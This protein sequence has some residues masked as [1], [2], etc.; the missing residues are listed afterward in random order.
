MARVNQPPRPIRVLSVDDNAPLRASRRTLFAQE[1]GIEL[2]A[3]AGDG[4]AGVELAATLRPDVVLLDIEMPVMNGIEAGEQIKRRLPDTRII[5][6]VAETT[7]RSQALALGADAFL[8]KDTPIDTLI[9]TNTRRRGGR[10]GG[11]AAV[12]D[13]RA[14]RRTGRAH[15][16]AAA[17]D[18]ARR[19]PACGGRG[20]LSIGRRAATVADNAA[21]ENPVADTGAAEGG[22]KPHAAAADSQRRRRPRPGRRT[23]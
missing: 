16:P 19:D 7:W 12:P 5:Y 1:E 17:P 6:F 9:R 20:G 18:R 23:A 14:A 4:R 11:G 2:V 13:C 3:D 21:A 10:P 22:P 15:R 8:L